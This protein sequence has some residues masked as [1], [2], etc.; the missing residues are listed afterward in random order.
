MGADV[1]LNAGVTS[2]RGLGQFGAA[3]VSSLQLSAGDALRVQAEGGW[4]GI[5]KVETGRGHQFYA[6]A[7]LEGQVAGGL[8]VV[9]GAR[10]IHANGGPWTKD[11]ADWNAGIGF[12]SVQRSSE[13]KVWATYGQDFYA[14]NMANARSIRGAEIGL[15][16]DYFRGSWGLR[17]EGTFSP[18]RYEQLRAGGFTPISALRLVVTIGVIRVF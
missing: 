5:R 7:H 13:V 12:R 6:S 14:R 2:S 17:T 18:V 9:V 3:G 10:S 4:R 1:A 15:R 8:Y 11:T 16:H